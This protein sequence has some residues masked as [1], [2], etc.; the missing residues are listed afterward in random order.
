MKLNHDRKIAVMGYLCLDLFPDLSGCGQEPFIPGRLQEIGWCP[1]FP[2]GVVGNTGVALQRLGIPVKTAG[3]IGDDLFGRFIRDRLRQLIPGGIEHLRRAD[4]HTGYCIVLSPP[5]CDRMFLAYRGINDDLSADDA[6][7][8]FL[9]EAAIL[10]FG[11]PPLCRRFASDHG[12]ELQKLF[13]HAHAHGLVTSLDMSLPSPGSFSYNLD[14]REFLCRTLPDTDLFLPSIE[15]LKFMFGLSG[16]TSGAMLHALS[17]RLLEFG[18]A[19]VGMKLGSDGLYVRTS[20]NAARLSFIEALADKGVDAWINR[21]FVVP[22]R[23][24]EVV[25]TTGAGDATIAG[26]L[27]GMFTGTSVEQAASL[28]VAVGA[29]SVTAS[30]AISGI[31][32]LREVA[33][34]VAAGQPV[35]PLSFIPEHLKI[36]S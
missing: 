12:A 2:G 24:V 36:L 23:Q 27:A 31:V 16:G 21:E 26:F 28:A 19:V 29:C 9:E 7:D 32:P 33:E 17:E 10:H 8:A 30:D 14:W 11:Y 5:R 4:G 25:G 34:Q 22:C 13:R 20:P 1:A 18:T 15:E 35:R 6:D 3:R